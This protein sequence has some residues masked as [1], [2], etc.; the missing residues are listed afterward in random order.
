M[1]TFYGFCMYVNFR[2]SD[3]L[4]HYIFATVKLAQADDTKVCYNNKHSKAH[5]GI[6]LY[7]HDHVDAK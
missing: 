5:L 1:L 2:F 6:V 7:S 4:F 3:L